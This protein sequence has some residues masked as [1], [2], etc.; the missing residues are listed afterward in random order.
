MLPLIG[1]SDIVA[2]FGNA[3]RK[4]LHHMEYKFSSEISQLSWAVNAYVCYTHMMQRYRL[5]ISKAHDYNPRTK[6]KVHALARVSTTHV[7]T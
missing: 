6:G 1:R 4:Y 2:K 5:P 7:Q 3:A